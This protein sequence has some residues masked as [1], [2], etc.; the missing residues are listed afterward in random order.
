MTETEGPFL[1]FLHLTPQQLTTDNGLDLFK[2]EVQINKGN[3]SCTQI[4]H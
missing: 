1:V 3:T 2:I 4:V